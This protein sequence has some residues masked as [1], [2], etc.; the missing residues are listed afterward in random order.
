MIA[1][2][3]KDTPIE[4]G[5]QVRMLCDK[6]NFY[7]AFE[8]EEPET[9]NLLEAKRK[10]DEMD[11]W[12]DNLV[13][14]FFSN[15]RKSDVLYQIMLG[16]NGCVTDMRWVV[17]KHDM[18]WNSNVEYKSGIVPGKKWIAELRIPRSSMPE[19]KGKKS[20]LANFTRG[21][22]LKNKNV[23]P[24]YVWSPFPKQ[25]PE[26]CGVV[27]IADKVP[28]DSIILYGDFEVKPYGKRFLGNWK[29]GQWYGNKVL[30]V[31][32]KTFRTAGASAVLTPGEGLTYFPKLKPNTKYLFSFSVKLENVK[33]QE[34]NA[35]G[36]YSYIRTGGPGPA[37]QYFSMPTSAMTGS[38]WKW[39]SPLLPRSEPEKNLIWASPCGKPP[40]RHGSTTCV[41]LK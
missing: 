10:F 2:S 36:F 16:S 18:K 17:K 32:N 29:K 11:L 40:V 5:T 30:I 28:N 39:S 37:K 23:L 13:E 33:A 4:V 25:N 3:K 12:R 31:D 14:L 38:V 35:S 15:D 19:L 21:R 9:N 7:F 6:D 26:N 8:C 24:Y 22:L 34:R 41:W 1:R 20:F 27:V